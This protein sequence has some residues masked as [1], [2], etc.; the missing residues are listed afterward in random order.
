VVLESAK[1]G[2]KNK[3][4]SGVTVIFER[5]E[6]GVFPRGRAEIPGSGSVADSAPPRRRARKRSWFTYMK[7]SHREESR[8]GVEG[9]FH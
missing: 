7:G 4:R 3:V 9:W 2:L 5:A 6:S 1:V 8:A